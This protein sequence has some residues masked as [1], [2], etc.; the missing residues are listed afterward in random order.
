MV[1]AMFGGATMPCDWIVVEGDSAYFKKSQKG[2]IVGR[3]ILKK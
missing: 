1:E 2:E 3:D